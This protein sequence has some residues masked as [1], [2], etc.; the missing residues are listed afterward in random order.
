MNNLPTALV[1]LEIRTTSYSE[2]FYLVYKDKAFREIPITPL[3]TLAIKLLFYDFCD[4]I[5][6]GFTISENEFT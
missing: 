6:L 2:S 1:L 5:P 3:H 4:L